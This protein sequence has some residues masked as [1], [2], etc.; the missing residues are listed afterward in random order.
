MPT[1]KELDEAYAKGVNDYRK[2]GWLEHFVHRFVH[3]AMRGGTR[4]DQS[5]EK[6][7]SDADEGKVKWK[8]QTTPNPRRQASRGRGSNSSSSARA[9]ENGTLKV[10]LIVAIVVAS[11]MF[12][13]CGNI[14]HWLDHNTPGQREYRER[15]R[16]HARRVGLN[17]DPGAAP[18]P[19]TGRLWDS[20]YSDR[21]K[22]HAREEGLNPDGLIFLFQSLCR[23]QQHSLRHKLPVTKLP[24]REDFA[25]FLS[26]PYCALA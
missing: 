16:E 23:K 19:Q 11:F 2:E 7:W 18:T 4:T 25:K 9:G 20:S 1:K 17:S 10:W 14:I 21:L 15:L 12:S 3:D 8:D 22:E 6:G 24:T 5:R 26:L 13:Y